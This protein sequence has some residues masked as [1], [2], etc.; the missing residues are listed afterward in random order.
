MSELKQAIVFKRADYCNNCNK[1]RILELYDR[2]DNPLNYT[3]FLDQLENGNKNIINKL[4]SFDLRY[5]KCRHCNTNY[6]IDWRKTY[7]IPLR[8]FFYIETF[9]CN[10]Y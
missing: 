7:P 9:L 3:Y 5:I 2:N 10:N 8:D 4:D 6:I 1:E